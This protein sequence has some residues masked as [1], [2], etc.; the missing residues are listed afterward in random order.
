MVAVPLNL[1]A[2]LNIIGVVQ[3]VLF[4]CALLGTKRGGARPNR[5]LAA[6]LFVI[7]VILTW[8]VLLHTQTIFRYPHLAQLHVPV[9]F[10][11]AP[12]LYFYVKSLLMKNWAFRPR[13]LLHLVPL[14]VGLL[15]LLPFY[16]QSG[17][18]KA[19]YLRAAF[20]N[21]PFEWRVR[22]ILVLAHGGAYMLLALMLPDLVPRR[23]ASDRARLSATSDLFWA[24][25]WTAALVVVWLASVVRFVFD[26]SVKSNLFVPLMFTALVNAAV[27]LRLR[28]AEVPE[29]ETGARAAAPDDNAAASKKYEKSTLTPQRAERYLQRLTDVM[30]A[31]KPFTDGDLTLQKLADKLSISPHHLSQIINEKL[32]QNF[33]DFVN[34]Y[35]VEEAKRRL[36]DPKGQHYS[37][38][39]I[40]ESV[41][42]NSKSAFNAVFKRHV[43]MTPSEWRKSRPALTSSEP[44]PPAVVH[45][46]VTPTDRAPES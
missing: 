29:E 35:R 26:Y 30:S 31:E 14:A 28:S 39:A 38:I 12:L 32:S 4:A 27:Y 2:L 8:N 16:L 23:R 33:A 22:T 25:A 36:V 15:Y 37:I 6:L 42:F 3:A 20:E 46:R 43:Q 45:L 40:A 11:T 44:T 18:Y 19:E 21:Y 5:L 41:G 13:D 10:L 24:R 17:E 7:A 1:L 9:Q 34:T